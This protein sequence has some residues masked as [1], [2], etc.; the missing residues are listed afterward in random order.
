M[1][2]IQIVVTYRHGLFGQFCRWW[3]IEWTHAAIRYKTRRDNIMVFET[4]GFGTVHRTWESFI[5][6]IDEYM[7]LETKQAIT[8]D[9]EIMLLSFAWGNVGKF[10]NF[11]RLFWIALKHLVAGR[12]A[13]VLYVNSHVCSSFVDACFHHIEIDLVSDQKDFWVTPDE[14]VKSPLLK[15]VE[16]KQ[17]W[18]EKK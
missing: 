10:Y 8:R 16:S 1:N 5:K 14:L 15:E 11:F 2:D 17:A 3:G 6:G 4:A 12:K 13:Q 7:I 9:Q 18:W